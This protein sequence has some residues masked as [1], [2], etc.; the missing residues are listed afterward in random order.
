MRYKREH[1]REHHKPWDSG[2]EKREVKSQEHLS[3]SGRRR[4]K[5]SPSTPIS[6]GQVAL[7]INYDMILPLGVPEEVNVNGAQR[8]TFFSVVEATAKR[9][10]LT[11]VPDPHPEAGHYYRSDHFSLSRVGIPAFPV[12]AG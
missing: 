2:V 10:G 1:D 6:P 3:V 5:I 8:T 11:I 9:F 7:D 12:D 4:E